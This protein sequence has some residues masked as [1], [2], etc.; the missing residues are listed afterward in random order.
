M[1]SVVDTALAPLDRARSALWRSVGA[2]PALR[3]L[4]TRRDTRI[5]IVATLG[6]AV[7]FAA[8]AL[9]PMLLFAVSPLVL[10]VPHV[11]SD[12]RYLMLRPRLPRL[13]LELGAAMIGLM[14]LTRV[15]EAWVAPGLPAPY[16]EGGLGFAWMVT[17]AVWGARLA[18]SWRAMRVLGPALA[19]A[20]ACIA[21]RPGAAM[22]A[23]PY[24]HNL[25][26]VALWLLLFKQARRLALAPL[27]AL[28][29][30]IALLLSGATPPAALPSFAGATLA[31]AAAVMAPG[32]PADLGARLTL[33]FV[34]TQAVHYAV[35]IGWI[36]QEQLR[37]QGTLSFRQ[38]ARG[39]RRD[40]TT[41]GV[42]LIAL[43]LLALWVL[44]T[45][46]LY[47]TRAL[48]LSL[49]NFHG[50]LELATLCFALAWGRSLCAPGSPSSR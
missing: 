19:A 34:F 12:V 20:A 49:A 28:A 21:W 15:L 42:A 41:A 1:A 8:T 33:V 7:A 47:G 17:G 31:D 6:V 30:G 48:Y 3:P 11:A 24:L 32:L 44:A 14:V 29:A 22:V 35:W 46:D 37:T 36:P 10:G 9:A 18:G 43:A 13:W 4:V 39:L 25:V 23:F 27:A 45:R 26:A 16:V 50:L 5:A 38:T 2:A 40:F